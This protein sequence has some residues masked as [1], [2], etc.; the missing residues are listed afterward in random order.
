[1]GA[2]MQIMIL[3]LGAWLGACATEYRFNST[4]EGAAVYQRTATQK[5]LL[6]E[7]PVS[8]GK[9][10]LPSDSPFLI[11]FEKQGYESREVAV[12]PTDNSLTSVSVQLKPKQPGGEDEG[13]RR[14]RTVIKKIFAVQDQ[15][16]QKRFV[17]A[18]AGLKLL[19]EVEPQL[20][21][22]Y[23]L[24]GSIYAVM[25]DQVQTQREWEKALGLDPGLEELKI[26]LARL[27]K[28]KEAKP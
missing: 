2:V 4:P 17:D 21:E 26:H 24:R 3:G 20:A 5:L 14:M 28:L 22:I 7:T 13:L 16:R 18:L 19:E 25:D 10:N 6:G 12:T 27:K 1:M 11:V 9:T 8:Y 23:V 15:I